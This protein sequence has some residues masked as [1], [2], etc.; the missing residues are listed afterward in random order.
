MS[1]T[2]KLTELMESLEFESEEHASY[3]DRDV[4]QIVMLEKRIL[5]AVEEGNEEGLANLPGWQQAEVETAKAI[6]DAR[7]GRFID[8]PGKFEFNEYRHMQQFIDSLDDSEAAEQLS[9]SIH[10]RG[11]F[12][13]FKDTLYRLGIQDQWYCYRDEA[14]RQ[15]VI[16][17]AE[18]NDVPCEDDTKIRRP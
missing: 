15:F 14:M 13:Y 2:A 8:P 12:R 6:R 10:G 1:P 17:W 11:A 9:C 7:A 3:F 16:E 18:S 5:H 4:G